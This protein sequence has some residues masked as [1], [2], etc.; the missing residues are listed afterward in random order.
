MLLT[1]GRLIG[2]AALQAEDYRATERRQGRPDFEVWDRETLLGWLTTSPEAGL[3]GTGDGPVLA[4]AGAI[5]AGQVTLVDLERQG[6]AWLPPLPGSLAAA[7]GPPGEA[8]ARQRRTAIE[9]AVLGNRLRRSGRLDLAAYT[10]L[11]LR[12]TWCHTISSS[13]GLRTGQ[14]FWVRGHVKSAAF[15]YRRTGGVL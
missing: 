8:A 9:A 6:R 14:S 4:L 13:P 11:L 2:G 10:A 3:A 12:A 7:A 1:T 5:D 15:V